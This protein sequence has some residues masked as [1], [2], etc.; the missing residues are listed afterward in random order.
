MDRWWQHTGSCPVTLQQPLDSAERHLLHASAGGCSPCG[1]GGIQELPAG[2]RP[3][4]AV[5]A[6][7][8]LLALCSWSCPCCTLSTPTWEGI[9]SR[10]SQLC[11]WS[12]GPIQ[13]V[14]CCQAS[15]CRGVSA[16][17]CTAAIPSAS[18]LQPMRQS[19]PYHTERSIRSYKPLLPLA[20][21]GYPTT[22]CSTSKRSRFP[23]WQ[24][25]P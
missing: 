9:H 12:C 18:S 8:L 13:L 4:G 14:S 20:G 17:G 16:M 19:A 2:H 7:F 10:D 25:P 6:S 3:A 11:C 23:T 15:S 21:A 1:L 5:Q 22:S 24:R